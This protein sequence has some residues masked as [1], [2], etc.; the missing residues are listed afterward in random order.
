VRAVINIFNAEGSEARRPGIKRKKE[1]KYLIIPG[2]NYLWAIDGHNKFRNYDIKIYAAINAYLY[3][4]IW[5]Y[6]GNSNRTEASV[7][8]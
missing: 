1:I 8:R 7:A 5:A 6:Y 4:I 2:L 3:L